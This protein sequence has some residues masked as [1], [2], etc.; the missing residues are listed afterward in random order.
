MAKDLKIGDKDK[1]GWTYIGDMDGE[2]VFAQ[3][4]GVI[5][6]ADAPRFAENNKGHLGCDYE[7][8]LLQEAFDN[9]SLTGMFNLNG[10]PSSRMVWGSRLD[11]VSPA[12]QAR[13]LKLREGEMKWESQQFVQAN[14]VLFQCRPRI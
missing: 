8:E 1:K 12:T 9:G 13:V 6:G 5:I 10:D 2:R 3:N 14:A 4:R 11:P 7:L